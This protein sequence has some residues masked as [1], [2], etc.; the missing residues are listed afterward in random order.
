M[1][2]EL[3]TI[4]D[5]EYD[6]YK[7]GFIKDNRVYAQS[8]E[9]N[10]APASEYVCEY[11][12]FDMVQFYTDHYDKSGIQSK[13]DN[14]KWGY[15]QLSTGRVVVPPIYDYAYP[16]Y[17]DRA[18]VQKNLKYG[19]I[20][21]KGREVVEIIWDDT[22]RAFHKA[23]CWVKK[24]DEFGYIDKDGAVVLP[25]QFEVAKGFQFIGESYEDQNYAALVKKDGK[26]GYIDEKGNYIFEPSFEDA[27][28]FSRIGNKP[29]MSYAPVMIYGKWGFIDKKGAFV[30]AFQFDDVGEKP[31]FGAEHLDFYTVNK[32]GQWGLMNA[33]FDHI[34]PLNGQRYVVYR[35][36]KIYIKD[37]KVTSTR[38]LKRQ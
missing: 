28:A 2:R 33:D 18:K 38:K 11:I 34:A 22:A 19:F 15:F 20:D 31:F 6:L 26:F 16:F 17:D 7:K 24:G 12:S 10:L 9:G 32:Y 25:P 23:L 30:V 5:C 1:D 21:P 3:C 13:E 4:Y 14:S 27:R 36:W 37:G 35:G 8:N 29:I